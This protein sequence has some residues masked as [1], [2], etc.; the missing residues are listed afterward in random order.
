MLPPEA[1]QLLLSTSEDYNE[2]ANNSKNLD[3]YTYVC[4]KDNKFEVHQEVM[5]MEIPNSRGTYPLSVYLLYHYGLR[6]DGEDYGRGFVEE[7][8]GDLQSLETPHGLL[9]KVLQHQQKY[10]SWFVQTV[11]QNRILWQK[12]LTVRLYRAMP[13]MLLLCKCRSTTTFVWLRNCSTYY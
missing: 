3:L 5:S 13:T 7:Y 9:S 11:Q 1:R 6:I 2:Q 10:C 12:P 4:R 8:I